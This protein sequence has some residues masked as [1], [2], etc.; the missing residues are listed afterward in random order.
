MLCRPG[1][2]AIVD[3]RNKVGESDYQSC[4]TSHAGSGQISSPAVAAYLDAALLHHC[5]NALT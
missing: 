1:N 5:G 4:V 3:G 2:H